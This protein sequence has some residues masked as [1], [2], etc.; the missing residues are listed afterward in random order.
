V[1][2]YDVYG[3]FE[4]A[5]LTG[6]DTYNLEWIDRGL[7]VL[8][9]DAT[10]HGIA[11]ALEVTQM[12]AM[13]RLAFRMGADLE[14]AFRH[15][16]DQLAEMMP[17]GRFITAFIGL[18]DPTGHTLTFHSGGQGPILHYRAASRECAV[19][20][21]TSFPL[22]AMPLSRL[23][24]PITLAFEPGDV[25]VLFSDGIY[26]Y[27]DPDGQ[28]YGEGRVRELMRS[29]SGLTMAEL[30]A[31]VLRSVRAFARGAPQED[32]ITLVL[33]R[34]EVLPAAAQ[35]A[36]ARDFGAIEQIFAFTREVFASHGIDPS[37]LPTVDLALEELFTNMV[38]YGGGD[39]P[40][41]ISMDKIAGGVE[42]T[43]VESGVGRFD[44][45]AAPE[46]DVNLPLEQRKP[47]GLGLHLVRRLVDSIDYAYD[48]Q[49]RQGRITIRKTLGGKAD[50]GD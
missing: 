32:D 49:R 46:P 47:G 11:P 42:V 9:G 5:D 23:D 33:V 43:L 14:T 20:M 26:E 38:K 7:L 8:L 48:E 1:P 22:A 4:P 24:P 31:E 6:G 30:A 21:P 2:G 35:W 25:L 44:P 15:V 50:A 36:F 13:L 29:S 18:L 19:H 12:Q 37:L 10:G 41:K 16:N 3:T 34:R 45:G 27:H 40:V 28:L 17:A 39:T